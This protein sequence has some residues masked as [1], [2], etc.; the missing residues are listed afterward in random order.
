MVQTVGD[1]Q[2]PRFKHH[3]IPYNLIKSVLR[4]PDLRRFVFDNEQWRAVF[5]EDHRVAPFFHAV[6]CDA[7]F[8]CHQRLRIM[9][10]I[11]QPCGELLAYVFFRSK[12]HQFVAQRI[13]YFYNSVLFF[14]FKR[15]EGN[16]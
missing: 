2:I 14:N 13:I 11:V 15:R 3:I 12:S 1:N 7:N 10:S 16:I 6:D 8:I 9:E 5:V 4:Y